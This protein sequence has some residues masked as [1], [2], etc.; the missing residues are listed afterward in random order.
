M[1]LRRM[2]EGAAKWAL[3][4]LRREEETSV[5]HRKNGVARSKTVIQKSKIPSSPNLIGNVSSHPEIGHG[6]SLDG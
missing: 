3:R 2:E 6:F 5:R 4:D 1:I